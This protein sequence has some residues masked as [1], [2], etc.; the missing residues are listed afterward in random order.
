MPTVGYGTWKSPKDQLPT[1]TYEAIKMGYRLIDEAAAY[2]NEKECGEGVKRAIDEGIVTRADLFITSKLWNTY[3]RPENVE[4]ACR[5]SLE[6]FGLE[7]FD[8]YIIHFPMS[9]K[10]VPFDVRYPPGMTYDPTIE[11]PIMIEDPVP[12]QDTWQAL[13]KL[14]DAGLVKNIGC[15]N[16][17]CQ[18]LRDVLSYAKHKPANLQVEIHPYLTQPKLVR[19]CKENGISCTAYSSFGGG[20]YVEMGRA[21][22]ADSCLTEP[23]IK[24]MAEKH[25]KTPG[26]IA[27]RWGV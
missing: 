22:E 23:A 10:F 18:M 1:C 26:Q 17:G 3:H 24:A 25:G 11:K 8:L 27:L 5:K 15:S 14:V 16:I 21:K 12:Y 6:D 7:Y 4:A 19:Y 9:L 2:G 13:E 20:S